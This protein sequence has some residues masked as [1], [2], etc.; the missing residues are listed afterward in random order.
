MD[1]KR[2]DDKIIIRLKKGDEIRE[3]IR[4]VAVAEDVKAAYFTGIGA[5]DS[6]KIGLW[7]PENGDYTWDYYDEDMEVT[8]LVGNVGTLDGKELVH[9]H[10]T[11][12]RAG[13]E[14]IGGHLDR[15]NCSLTMEIFMDVIDYELVKKFDSDLGINTIEFE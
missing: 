15:G 9:A 10:I 6:I 4:E 7:L 1:Y 14:I 12:G 13:S 11:C 8:S 5:V 2:F 3:S